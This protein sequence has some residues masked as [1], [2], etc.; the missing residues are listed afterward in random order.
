MLASRR[1]VAVGQ[2][3]LNCA[4]LLSNVDFAVF[5][6]ARADPAEHLD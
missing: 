1:A 6:L 5:S 2:Q 3:Q 4:N